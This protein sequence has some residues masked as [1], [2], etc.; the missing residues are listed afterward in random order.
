MGKHE[1]AFNPVTFTPWYEYVAGINPALTAAL[2]QAWKEDPNLALADEEMM[3][4][5][6]D[7][8][9]R[10][11]ASVA[12]S[13]SQTGDQAGAFGDQLNGLNKARAS[14]DVEQLRPRLTEVMAGTAKMRGSVEALQHKVSLSQ[15]EINK[16]RGD[17]DR[18]TSEALLCPQ[19]HDARS[20]VDGH[21]LGW[22]HRDE[23]GRRRGLADLTRRCG[24]VR[25]QEGRAR[26]RRHPRLSGGRITSVRRTARPPPRPCGSRWLPCSCRCAA[27]SACR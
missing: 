5:I 20:A 19:P 4:Q 14:R 23:A 3:A 18:A 13:A 21:H 15:D 24:L 10:L 12:Q 8:T 7:G 17:L 27:S 2:D 26:S 22:R 16:L 1:T 11:L 6:S 9:E 25:R